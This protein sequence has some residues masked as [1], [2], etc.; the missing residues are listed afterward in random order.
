MK[1]DT[2]KRNTI[3][4]RQIPSKKTYRIFCDNDKYVF[5]HIEDIDIDSCPDTGYDDSCD[6][7]DI[8]KGASH[9]INK[10][11]IRRIVLRHKRQDDSLKNESI[12]VYFVTDKKIKYVLVDGYD[13][14]AAE[15]FFSDMIDVLETPKRIGKR[16][17]EKERNKED[18]WIRSSSKDPTLFRRLLILSNAIMIIGGL[19]SI[20]MYW[21]APFSSAGA[22]LFSMLCVLCFTFMLVAAFIFPQYFSVKQISPFHATQI[23]NAKISILPSL[24][25]AGMGPCCYIESVIYVEP[26]YYYT[27]AV[28][29]AFCV[30]AVTFRRVGMSFV[31]ALVIL[32]GCGGIVNQINH[33][34][35]LKKPEKEAVEF[36]DKYIHFTGTRGGYHP[37]YYCKVRKKSGVEID[38]EVNEWD[39]ED[40]KKGE[41]YILYTYHG[42]LGLENIKLT[43]IV[44]EKG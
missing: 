37:V 15:S 16:F 13:I 14:D 34:L 6:V 7:K 38:I 19:S 44:V 5:S 8:I 33:D 43:T 40:M 26:G 30:I 2:I 35:D 28:I 12:Y 21:A 42:G 17:V 39:W 9:Y 24:I 18:S 29:F 22:K 1:K 3:L 32:A 20:L 27:I 41:R 11:D 4:V 25:A 36:V 31:L 23:R 10:K